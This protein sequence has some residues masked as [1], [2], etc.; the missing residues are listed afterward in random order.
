[1]RTSLKVIYQKEDAN[2]L[3]KLIFLRDTGR[4]FM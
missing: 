3:G 1:M 2:I 4:K